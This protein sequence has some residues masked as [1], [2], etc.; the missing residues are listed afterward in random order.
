MESKTQR[1]RNNEEQAT[2]RK[3]ARRE[4]LQSHRRD[5]I[6]FDGASSTENVHD[7]QKLIMGLEYA[8]E[9]ER[10]KREML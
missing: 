7:Y 8:L 1:Q 10:K 2:E 3:N 6:P 9:L 5:S 4:R